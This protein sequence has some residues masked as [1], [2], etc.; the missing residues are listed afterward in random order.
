MANRSSSQMLNQSLGEQPFRRRSL[1]KSGA[2]LVGCS[3]LAPFVRVC[4]E[5]TQRLLPYEEYAKH[6]A[7][8]LAELVRAG[9]VTANELL[10]AAIAR[11]D[12]I[13]PKI[14]AIAG[15]MYD[16]A[17]KSIEQGLPDGPLK[18]VPFLVKDLSFAMKGVEASFGSVLFKGRIASTDSTIVTRYRKAGLVLFARTQVPELGILP[19]TESILAGVTRNPFNLDRTAGGSSGGSA[20]AVAAGIAPMASASDGGGSIRIP[21]S[22]CGLFGLKPSRARVPIGPN[23]FESWGGLAVLHAVTRSVRDSAALLDATAGP[24]LGDGYHAPHHEG[25][26]LQ[27]VKKE[28]GK[29]RIAIV[30]S[31]RPTRFVDAECLKAVAETAVLCESLG[32]SVEECTN[33]FAD[34]FVFHELRQS[35]GITVLV[36]LRRRVLKRLNE[37]RRELRDDDL[38]PVTRIYFDLAEKYTAVQIE[39][40]RAAFFRAARSMAKFQTKY[41][42]ILTP[43]LATPPIEHGRITM[44]GTSQAVLQGLLDFMPCTQMANWTGQPA[45]SVPLHQTSDGLPVGVQFFA[46][47]GDETTL[48]RLAGQ[49]EE[50]RPWAGRRP[51]L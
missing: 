36:S 40:A 43:T 31:M 7:V 1:L 5:S 45:M 16:M 46:R 10:E 33:E 48:F 25:G 39:D 35:H 38:E 44:T 41:D 12:V 2:A 37:L 42:V 14:N 11:A 13:D 28:P 21:A 17:R 50:A 9:E 18:G 22:C 19:T 32:H 6:D 34:H 3:V 20:A 51:D 4:A 24:E 49:L 8:G 15:T 27:E 30:R 26:F 29:L 47:H 23:A